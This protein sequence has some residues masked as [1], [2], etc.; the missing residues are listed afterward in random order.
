MHFPGDTFTGSYM[1]LINIGME[2][3]AIILVVSRD[4]VQ[5]LESLNWCWS[6]THYSAS[7]NQNSNDLKGFTH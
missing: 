2:K 6:T 1:I 4:E 3:P 5:L 7:T